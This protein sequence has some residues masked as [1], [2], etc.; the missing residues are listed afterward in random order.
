MRPWSQSADASEGLFTKPPADYNQLTWP[1]RWLCLQSDNALIGQGVNSH[2]SLYVLLDISKTYSWLTC[3]V[4]VWLAWALS[5]FGPTKL[6]VW[7]RT[8]G[9]HWETATLQGLAGFLEKFFCCHWSDVQ[10]KQKVHVV[11]VKLFWPP[12]SVNICIR[13]P[14]A[15]PFQLLLL[16]VVYSEQHRHQLVRNADFQPI[17]DLLNQNLHFIRSPG[18][19]QAQ[20]MLRSSA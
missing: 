17:P 14:N 18:D 16:K 9:V 12:A 3:L 4:W 2:Q 20:Q 15:F 5:M 13:T 7:S 19:S 6:R 1:P 8:W 11:P 10:G